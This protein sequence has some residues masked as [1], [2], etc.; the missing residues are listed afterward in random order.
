MMAIY[1][2][3]KLIDKLTSS[4]TIAKFL[5][6]T[7]LIICWWIDDMLAHNFGDMILFAF[8]WVKLWAW[9]SCNGS[10]WTSF[11]HV[12][13]PEPP[14][15]QYRKALSS[16]QIVAVAKTLVIKMVVTL[17]LNCL[18]P[19][20]CNRSKWCKI[21]TKALLEIKICVQH[22]REMPIRNYRR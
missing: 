22:N 11:W 14:D 10:T 9:L 13:F 19:I 5:P 18:P 15:Q 6:K 7:S 17:S 2:M 8:Y 20:H 3:E 12:F 4:L 21:K 1:L 16:R